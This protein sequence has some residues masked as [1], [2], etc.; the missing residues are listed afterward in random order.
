MSMSTTCRLRCYASDGLHCAAVTA[1][2][3]LVSCGIMHH[4]TG[5]KRGKVWRSTERKQWGNEKQTGTRAAGAAAVVLRDVESCSKMRH[6]K[7][8]ANK[9]KAVQATKHREC[10]CMVSSSSSEHST[11]VQYALCAQ[12]R[13][14]PALG[15]ACTAACAASS[16]AW[17]S[18]TS[19][20]HCAEASSMAALPGAS[21]RACL[22]KESASWNWPVSARLTAS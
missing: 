10:A 14:A 11:L 2:H 6:E 9:M 12:L 7:Q 3:A 13:C 18:S 22:S 15:S 19:I 16:A 5:A 8:D 4:T 1:R 20:K 17:C 21:C